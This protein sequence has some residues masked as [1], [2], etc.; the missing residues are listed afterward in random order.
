MAARLT[1]R[2][3]LCNYYLTYRCNARCSFC[4]IWERPSPYVTEADVQANLQDLKRLGVRV[5]DFTGGEPLLHREL[6]TF[7]RLAKDLGFLTTVTTNALL[8]PKYGERL[9]G[10][11][12]MLHFSLDAPTKAEHDASRG[13]ACFDAFTRSLELALAWGER[14]DILYTITE[15][16]LAGI[17]EVYQTFVL[18]HNLL[19]ILNPVFTYNQVG[20][21]LSQPALQTLRAWSS[22]PNAYLNEAF[23]TLRENGGNDIQN[24]VCNAGDTTVVISPHNELI[25]PCYHLEASA[26]PIRGELYALWNQPEIKAIR[27]QAGRLSAC[28]GC[29]V[30]CYMQPAFATQ[31]NGYFWEALPSTLKYSLE[32]WVFA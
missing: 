8:Y 1:R 30:N 3:V 6:P 27:Q 15:S 32:K 21:E 29:T 9:R 20:N 14:P 7:L 16:S 4:D 10:L 13:V 5:I 26:H 31:V 28:Q 11:V 17:D 2:P 22:R 23:I 19:L 12:D 24:P 18:P 25:L